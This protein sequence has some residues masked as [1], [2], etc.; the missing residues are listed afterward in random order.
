LLEWI[1]CGDPIIGAGD[2]SRNRGADVAR[3]LASPP[4]FGDTYPEFVKAGRFLRSSS[5]RRGCLSLDLSTFGDR[6]PIGD[7]RAVRLSGRAGPFEKEKPRRLVADTLCAASASG[8][9]TP[10]SLRVVPG[11]ALRQS[12]P[13]TSVSKLSSAAGADDLLFVDL[14]FVPVFVPERSEPPSAVG[15]LFPANRV[16]TLRETTHRSRLAGNP[17]YASLMS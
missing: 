7:R 4:S 2:L 17:L 3:L 12:W 8:D 6:S 10:R 14:L 15:L 16:S 9:G 11:R 1:P 13:L 5:L